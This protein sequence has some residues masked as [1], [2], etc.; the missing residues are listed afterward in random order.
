MMKKLAPFILGLAIF[1]I[2]PSAYATTAGPLPGGTI[3]DSSATG[4][5]AWVNPNNVKLDDGV[6]STFTTAAGTSITK[7]H[8]IEATN[9][10]FSIPA[11]ATINGI[12]VDVVRKASSASGACGTGALEI[13]DNVVSLITSGGS[14]ISTNK[15]TTTD[16]PITIATSTY[17]NGSDLWSATWGVSDINSSNFG[18]AIGAKGAG[19]GGPSCVV[20]GTLVLTVSHGEVPI[21]KLQIGEK[22]WSYST[23]TKQMEIDTVTGVASEPI[24]VDLN[25]LYDV[26]TSDGQ[27]VQATASHLFYTHGQW[28]A[29]PDLKVGNT[30]LN[31][32]LHLVKITKIKVE[33]KPGI[34]VW[35]I[36]V[37]KNSNFFA[38]HEL[39]HNASTSNGSVDFI[40]ITVTY[41]PAA[42]GGGFI[43][44]L[45]WFIQWLF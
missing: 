12:Q 43:N 16:W 7:S 9:F 14:L 44:G 18:V 29:A 19:L 13:C 15:A 35:N 37:K 20:A 39:V 8:Y 34:R 5:V 32:H 4:T 11:G 42:A 40:Q 41:T 6:F 23:S 33:D 22:I 30:L 38:N 36:S 3:T 21:E 10:G 24:S 45:Q 25:K 26:T 2:A 27:T 1:A 17:G 31:S 28:V